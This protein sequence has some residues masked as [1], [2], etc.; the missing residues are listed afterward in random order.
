MHPRS[1][2]TCTESSTITAGPVAVP[3]PPL[4][5]TTETT[6]APAVSSPF[7]LQEPLIIDLEELS[8]IPPGPY[9]L[10]E[11]RDSSFSS[12]ESLRRQV[13]LRRMTLTC[14]ERNFLDHL[15]IH[16]N[17]VEVQLAFEK[18][19]DDDIFFDWQ[20]P[21]HLKAGHDHSKKEEK[22]E[23]HREQAPSPRPFLNRD[24]SIGSQRRL[25]IIE[26]RKQ[27]KSALWQAHES[28]IAVTQSA[29]KKSLLNRTGSFTSVLSGNSHGQIP[30]VPSANSLASSTVS[31]V[32]QSAEIFRRVE[33][34]KM[35]AASPMRKARYQRSRSLVMIPPPRVPEPVKITAA[36]RSSS[37]SRKSV[38][39][40]PETPHRESK[41]TL[42]RSVSD[43]FSPPSLDD[44]NDATDPK[45]TSRGRP[46][47]A[48]RSDSVT[49]IPSIQ[50]A[51]PVR[52][53]SISSI[54]S[55]HHAN[56][57]R[58]DS[59]GSIP[60]IH[61]ANAIRSN[62]VASIPSIHSA[63][64]IHNRDRSE[65]LS[66]IPSIHHGNCINS[67]FEDDDPRSPGTVSEKKILIHRNSVVDE[68]NQQLFPTYSATPDIASVW[69]NQKQGHFKS[70]AIDVESTNS[71]PPVITIPS[72]NTDETEGTETP[73]AEK[74]F[75]VNNKSVLVR[76][77]SRNIYEGEGMEVTE[78]DENERP[79]TETQSFFGRF[80][81]MNMSIRTCNSFDDETMSH[82]SQRQNNYDDIFRSS[83]RRTLSDEEVAAA[84]ILVGSSGTS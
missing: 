21:R 1:E 61:H 19:G 39:F 68:N 78:L 62:S 22:A 49:S 40:H 37:A 36:R 26:D 81:S 79:M 52:S 57:I 70:K 6:P 47:L 30:L 65:S 66:S 71:F 28:G 46:P 72:T 43:I 17:E 27:E 45:P 20:T 33:T 64:P 67:L 12:R 38:T 35:R 3:P 58:S 7:L 25:K 51:H 10:S 55:I 83:I 76:R 54:P 29:S 15:V 42:R 14:P 63:H 23:D 34:N 41:K 77:A 11:A 82:Y 53:D 73:E 60:S 80:E 56:A 31:G 75:V 59:I 44:D 74:T 9:T 84:N 32:Q 13:E 69:L 18:L 8:K 2:S 5:V 48:Q 24:L 50:Y 4:P 16:G